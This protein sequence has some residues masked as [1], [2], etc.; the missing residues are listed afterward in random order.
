[1][2]LGAWAIPVI[3]SNSGVTGIEGAG[4]GH[5]V[6]FSNRC[7]VLNHRGDPLGGILD[8]QV[9]FPVN[10]SRPKTIFCQAGVPPSMLDEDLRDLE[11]PAVLSGYFLLIEVPGVIRWRRI[12]Y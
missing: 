2:V 5:T 12:G 8:V 7:G 6:S 3:S 1:M 10:R 11:G 9:S 4:Q